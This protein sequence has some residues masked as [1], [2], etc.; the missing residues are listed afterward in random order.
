MDYMVLRVDSYQYLQDKKKKYL[1][2]P[3]YKEYPEKQV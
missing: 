3:K 2:I 1:S